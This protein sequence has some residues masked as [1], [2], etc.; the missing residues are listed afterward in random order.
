[1]GQNISMLLSGVKHTLAD[2]GLKSVLMETMG[3]RIRQLR[4]ARGLTQDQLGSRVSVTGAAVSQW[5]RGETSNIK[6]Q[7]FLNLCEELGTTPEYLAFGADGPVRGRDGRYR[8]QT[9][10]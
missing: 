9:N 10:P 6:I 7:T 3:D 4:N 5:E 1:M 8:R 2:T